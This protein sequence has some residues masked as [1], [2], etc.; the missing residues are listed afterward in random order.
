MTKK[1]NAGKN[2]AASDLVKR[3]WDKKE[4]SARQSRALLS[5]WAKRKAIT[6]A[7]NELANSVDYLRK[8]E[9]EASGPDGFIG[10]V[11][12]VIENLEKLEAAGWKPKE[13]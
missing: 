3:R 4:S 13:R 2:K 11:Y 8:V 9:K 12:A 1:K 7:H 10:A 5:V 6:D